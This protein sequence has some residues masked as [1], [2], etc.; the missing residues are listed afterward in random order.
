MPKNEHTRFTIEDFEEALRG[1]ALFCKHL[2][3]ADKGV[4]TRVRYFTEG[5]MK[6][7]ILED[8]MRLPKSKEVDALIAKYE[9]Q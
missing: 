9:E 8:L 2:G 4:Y 6:R 7:Q 5:L 1:E 3:A